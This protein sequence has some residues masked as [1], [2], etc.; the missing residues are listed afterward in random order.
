MKQ[1]NF[2]LAAAVLAALG[3]GGCGGGHSSQHAT[4]GVTTAPMITPPL[5]GTVVNGVRVV[6]VKAKR[7]EFTPDTIVVNQG[8]RVRLECRSLDVLHALQIKAYKINTKVRPGMTQDV[9]FTATKSGTFP[10]NCSMD[11]G[12][13]HSKMK[14]I[15][16]VKP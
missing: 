1:D 12:S 11:C 16:I 5:S 2:W 4:V 7:Y 15:L 6:E 9:T 8:E 13:G 3:L 10:F 14:G